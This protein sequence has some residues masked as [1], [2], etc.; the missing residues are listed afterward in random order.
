MSP[1]HVFFRPNDAFLLDS[2]GRNIE[3]ACHELAEAKQGAPADMQ[4]SVSF[5]TARG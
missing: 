4:P 5:Q 1:S 2:D 3:A